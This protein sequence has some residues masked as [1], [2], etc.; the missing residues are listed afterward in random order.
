MKNNC[1]LLLLLGLIFPAIMVPA[2]V[3]ERVKAYEERIQAEEKEKEA[4]K[5]RAA[6][7]RKVVNAS[8]ELLSKAVDADDLGAV[9]A[10]LQKGANIN[11]YNAEG[12]TPL[13]HAPSFEMTNFLLKN[14]A[15][16]NM[17]SNDEDQMTAL[18]YAGPTVIKL[19]LEHGADINAKDANGYT[20]LMHAITEDDIESAHLLLEYGAD[21][22]ATDAFGFTA[23][24]WAA[25]GN[26]TEAVKL[27][28]EKGANAQLTNNLDETALDLANQQ[29]EINVDIVALLSGKR[30]AK[31]HAESKIKEANK[32]R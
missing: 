6:K 4:E 12:L 26:N 5:K 30:K 23:L 32:R 9:E 28:L 20:A 19:L 7:K 2:S 29:E 22:N 3:K 1:Y 31:I 8:D 15:N 13:M 27:L 11:G 17:R 24:M 21:I 18:M 16:V 14:K 10:A 25:V